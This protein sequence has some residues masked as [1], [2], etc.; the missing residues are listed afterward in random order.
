L[1][2][3]L[4]RVIAGPTFGLHHLGAAD[5]AFALL[6]GSLSV[7]SIARQHG[8]AAACVAVLAMTLP[9]AF[10][11]RNPLPVLGILAA[12]AGVNW[13]LF[14][15]LVRCG[16]AL[17]AVFFAA[18]AAGDRCARRWSLL[19]GA[20]LVAA[21]IVGQANSDPQLGPEVIVYMLPIAL[22]FG[23]LGRLLRLRRAA[24]A[25]LRA[26][27][28][29]LRVQR[30]QTAALAVAADRALI[31]EDLDG[32]LHDRIDRIARA[33]AAGR[34]SL[35]DASDEAGGAFE[36]I[37]SEGRE[38]LNHMREVVSNLNPGAPTEPQPVLARLDS[39][40]ENVA[41][42]EAR[43]TVTG[44]PRTLPPGVELSGYRIVE[45]LLLALENSPGARID[46]TVSFTPGA[47]ELAVAGQMSTR[48]SGR[49]AIAAATEHAAT[50]GG[51]VRTRSAG[52]RR[53]T[54]VLL[55]L[56]TSHV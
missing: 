16:T 50:L 38:T 4:R 25:D 11:R 28:E 34:A 6:L 47:L 10:A 48:S 56:A 36:V 26:R 30:D 24:V 7:V 54:V 18:F 33:A 42:A 45:R 2:W 52:G 19:L 27:T 15:G 8:S 55:P 53:E 51:T 5:I 31:A 37:Q 12:G 49:M 1:S 9:V 29:E 43:L 44:D 20:V 21:N 23:V 3:P 13:W 22:A 17:P 32:Y 35:P 40:I 46:V 14:D 41:P 39:L